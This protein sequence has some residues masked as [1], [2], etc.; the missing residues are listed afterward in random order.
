[1]THDRLQD[2]KIRPTIEH[3]GGHAISDQGCCNGS[4][5]ACEAADPSQLTLERR[6]CAPAS[7]RVDQES[8]LPFPAG[9]RESLISCDEVPL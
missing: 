3:V 1:M 6:G 8:R 4:G 2:A 5:V 7:L 9:L